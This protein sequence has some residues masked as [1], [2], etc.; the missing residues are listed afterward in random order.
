MVPVGGVTCGNQVN[1]TPNLLDLELRLPS[2]TV[3]EK[4]TSVLYLVSK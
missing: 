4:D 2:P 1:E 3:S